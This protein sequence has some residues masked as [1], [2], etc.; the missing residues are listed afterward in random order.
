MDYPILQKLALPGLANPRFADLSLKESKKGYRVI[1][2]DKGD[3]LHTGFY[4]DHDQT[5][6][7]N[8]ILQTT[9]ELTPEEAFEVAQEILMFSFESIGLET[10]EHS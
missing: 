10:V 6:I 4:L 2:G 1:G 8:P 5:I 3:L 9:L 7:H